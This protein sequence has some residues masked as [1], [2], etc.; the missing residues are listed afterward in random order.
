[1]HKVYY[2]KFLAFLMLAATVCPAHAYK[3]K[4]FEPLRVNPLAVPY[5]AYQQPGANESY[6]KITQLEFTLFKKHMKEK[7]SITGLHD[8]KINCLEETLIICLLQAG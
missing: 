8:W 6:P 4:T 3:V 2:V 7:I 1:M 5:S